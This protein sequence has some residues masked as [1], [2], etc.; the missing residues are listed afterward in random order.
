MSCPSG[1]KI[2]KDVLLA[3]EDV[4]MKKNRYVTFHIRPNSNVCTIDK[5]GDKNSTFQDLKNDLPMN[6]SR[7]FVFDCNYLTK[8]SLGNM[9][10]ER[11]L[12]VHWSPYQKTPCSTKTIY[13]ASWGAVYK[14]IN[15]SFGLYKYIEITEPD[16]L[17]EQK[18][19]E[20]AAPIIDLL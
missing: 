13:C 10:R 7:Y 15:R 3:C 9:P 14:L 5:R 19:I 20:S 16:E 2:S 4:R 18:L 6:Q 1:V 11:L 12:L 8:E 17:S